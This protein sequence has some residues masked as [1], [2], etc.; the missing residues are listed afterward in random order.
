MGKYKG[1][2][3]MSNK[4]LEQELETYNR[5]HN[6]LINDIGKFIVIHHNEVI[7]IFDTY[8]DALKVGYDR[9]GNNSFLVKNIGFLPWDSVYITRNLVF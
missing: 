5:I 3:V 7:G 4:P 1:V 2:I 8:S 6:T 9:C